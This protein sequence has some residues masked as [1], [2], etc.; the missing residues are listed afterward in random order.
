MNRWTAHEANL[1]WQL[2][3]SPPE[4]HLEGLQQN[5]PLQR[6]HLVGLLKPFSILTHLDC[7]PPGQLLMKLL[8]VQEAA[9]SWT[10]SIFD[11][12]DATSRP[13]STLGFF[14]LKVNRWTAGVPD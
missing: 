4:R 13:L 7:L 14:L 8:A 1:N 3:F 2:V 10:F 6:A 9:D 5:W 11:L 12:S